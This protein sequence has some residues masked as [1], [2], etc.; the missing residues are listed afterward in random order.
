MLPPAFAPVFFVLLL[1]RSSCAIEARYWSFFQFN[2]D[3]QFYA[4]RA[5][6]DFAVWWLF[7]AILSWSFFCLA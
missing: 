1:H 7:D 5:A 3:S 4:G 2:F 6:S